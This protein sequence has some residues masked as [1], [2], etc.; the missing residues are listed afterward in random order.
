MFV[1]Q[2]IIL[3]FFFSKKKIINN[4]FS[5][6]NNSSIILAPTHRSRWDGLVLTMAM[7]RRITNKDCRFMVTK[8]EMKGMQGWFLKRLG[9]FSINQL[10]PSLSTL[11]F[12]IDLVEKGEQL[13]V[14]PEGKINKYGR[15]LVL[16]EG[17]YRLARLASKKTDSIIIIPIGIAYSEV[18]PKFRSEFCL[19]F[20]K[21]IAMTD[22]L[23]T[24]IKE[25]NKFLN[26]NMMK[27]EEIALKNVGR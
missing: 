14:F 21:P 1:T 9:C 26:Q 17:L 3:R 22:Y 11:R 4:C 23:N 20:G 8:S 19:S 12:A 15:K 13:V 10:S 25:F 5:I 27:E 16:R 18:S 7:G 6:P 2:D 24:T